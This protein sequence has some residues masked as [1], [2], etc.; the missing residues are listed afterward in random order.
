M[1]SI[2]V[3]RLV[4][5]RVGRPP[6]PSGHRLD[7]H[8]Q[9]RK[10]GQLVSD[11]TAA[12]WPT[13]GNRPLPVYQLQAPGEDFTSA[14]VTPDGHDLWT[15]GGSAVRRWPTSF[16]SAE[17]QPCPLLGDASIG[18]HDPDLLPDAPNEA[19]CR[20]TYTFRMDKPGAQSAGLTVPGQHPTPEPG[21]AYD[22]T[23]STS[24]R[25]RTRLGPDTAKTP[26]GTRPLV[27]VMALFYSPRIRRLWERS[28]K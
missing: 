19:V 24:V 6:H 22:S 15:T 9:R 5:R 17:R 12:L 18:P 20:L 27:R 28:H 7:H 21:P 8:P 26:T 4:R 14:H 1:R 25:A 10:S 16:R 3:R 11:G 13:N 23:D 2:R